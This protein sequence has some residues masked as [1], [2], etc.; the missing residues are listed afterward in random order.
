MRP[1][2]EEPEEPEERL[3][4]RL[5]EPLRRAEPPPELWIRLEARARAL[6][7]RRRPAAPW[8]LRLASAA[9]GVLVVLGLGLG[10]ERSGLGRPAARD[11]L[12]AL[13][14][15]ASRGAALAEAPLER[16]PEQLLLAHFRPNPEPKR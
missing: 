15:L 5:F 1:T 10:A 4:A 8:P 7:A 16:L 14:D 3:L 6:A 11:D 9:A 13:Q 12:H 2:A